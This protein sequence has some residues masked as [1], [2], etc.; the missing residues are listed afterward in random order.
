MREDVRNIYCIGR[1]YAAHAAELGNAVPQEEPV[2][3]MKSSASLRPL[4][5]GDLA[6]EH[7][8]F[9]HEIELVLLIG[10]PVP[11]GKLSLDANG[12]DCV[13]AVGLGLDLTRRAKQTE[14][15]KAGLPWTASKSFAGSAF[16][17]PMTP[18][19]GR[20]NLE[21]IS[22]ALQVN[23]VEKQ[24]GHVNQMIFSIPAQLQ[25]LNSL[26]ALLPGDLV[27]TGTPEGVGPLRKGDKIHLRYLSG[28][29]GEYEGIV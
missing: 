3:F 8:V 14:L 2:I 20:F 7:E 25:Y 15:K 1:N 18:C 26:T 21:D 23:G 24:R 29:S 12:S 4:G 28:P 16:L 5:K 11:R 27:F 22:F 17:S 19:D 9:H 10:T 13:R 6:F